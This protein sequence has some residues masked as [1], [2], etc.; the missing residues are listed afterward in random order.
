MSRGIAAVILAAGAGSRMRSALPKPL[1][2]VAG[3]PMIDLVIDAIDTVRPAVVVVVL[4]PALVANNDI[5]AHLEMRLGER[6]RIAT[7]AEP[8][9]TGD[10]L[11]SAMPFLEDAD[12]VMVAF[13][14]HPLLEAESISKLIA[15]LGTN[16]APLALLTCVHPDGGGFG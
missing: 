10:A 12:A 16:G 14:D 1:H 8:R 5:V 4:S 15:A 3:R 6:L 2:T 11:L 7:Q 9:G 13:A